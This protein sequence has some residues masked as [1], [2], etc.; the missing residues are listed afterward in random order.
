M[1]ELLFLA[2]RIPYPP[3][4]GDKIRSWNI[5]KFL[6][7]HYRVHLGCFIDDPEDEQHRSTLE[8]ICESCQFT[9]LNPSLAKL[10]S[11]SGMISGSPLTLP[12]FWDRQLARW[13]DALIRDRKIEHVFVFSSSMAQYAMGDAASGAR[14]VVDYVDVDSD[15]WRQYA[16]A[17]SWPAGWIYGRESRRLLSFEREVAAASDASLFVSEAEADLFRGLAPESA[18]KIGA[19]NNGVD[20]EFFDPTEPHERPFDG[21][22]PTLVFTGAMDYWANVD[23]VA[24]FANEVFPG[25][26]AKCP[27]A[28]FWIVGARPSTQVTGLTSIPGVHVTGSVPDIRPYMAHADI[29]V[30]PL[31]LARGIQNKVLEAMAMARPIIASPEALEGIEA[32]IGRD[33]ISADG[34]QA[35]VEQTINL[36]GQTGANEMG[37]CARERVVSTYGWSSNL[38]GLKTLLENK[39]VN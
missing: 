37:D 18:S 6:A 19:L 28:Q 16:A 3:N 9:R 26:R 14:R 23:A 38:A 10:R 34:A 4:K 12:Y 31:R 7:E 24:W 36:L 8:E 2:H 25:I 15:K 35:F 11:L 17:K 27:T 22:D 13:T 29:I 33:I 39:R 32:E 20:F 1:S 21:T 5:L 30:A